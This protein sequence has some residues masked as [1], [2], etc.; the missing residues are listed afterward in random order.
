M[1]LEKFR[2]TKR[3]L[4]MAFLPFCCA[5]QTGGIDAAAR[6]GIDAGNGAWISGMKEARAAI[7]AATYA[8][9]AVD[10][11]ATGDCIKGRAAIE[12][13]LKE[14]CAKLGKAVSASVTSSGSVQHGGFVYEWGRA[15]A[16]FSDGKKLGGNY[17]T[18]WQQQPNGEWKI[19][20]N[21]A[22]PADKTY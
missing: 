15:E 13:H 11:S 6:R 4:V 8:D 18:A 3:M 2:V 21:L 10:C 7:I 9:N 20:R 14:R 5:G 12:Q 17:L 19:F 1:G 22:I 16:T